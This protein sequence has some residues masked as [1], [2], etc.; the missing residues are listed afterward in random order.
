MIFFI[1]IVYREC[2]CARVY[3]CVHVQGGEV[4]R[5]E[6]SLQNQNIIE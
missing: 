1:S 2:G 5:S 6:F 4:G 3:V